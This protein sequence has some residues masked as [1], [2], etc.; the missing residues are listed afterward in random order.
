MG[1]ASQNERQRLQPLLEEEAG[2]RLAILFGSLA[3]GRETAASDIDIAIAKERPL[4]VTDKMALIETLASALGRPV[5]LVD[6]RTVGEPL[7]GRILTEGERLLVRDE[8]LLAELIK[9]HLFDSADFL[10][11][12]QRILEERRRAWTGQ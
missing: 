4:T 12:R 2:I 5:D 1:S 11:L 10:P 6:L 7:L 8:R 9:K 3:K